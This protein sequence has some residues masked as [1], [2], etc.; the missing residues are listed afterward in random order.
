MLLLF[1]GG[2]SACKLKRIFLS[3]AENTHIITPFLV[4][5]THS[6]STM[7]KNK[8]NDNK[9][10]KGV[11]P[12]SFSVNNNN[13]GE[14]G[15]AREK[16]NTHHNQSINFPHIFFDHIFFC[17]RFCFHSVVCH[18]SCKTFP[19]FN[20]DNGAVFSV[21]NFINLH[22]LRHGRFF[23]VSLLAGCRWLLV[24]THCSFF[25]PVL[26]LSIHTHISFLFSFSFDF[27]PSPF[28]SCD[29]IAR[30]DQ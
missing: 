4:Q 8:N 3:I 16:Q 30:N 21:R 2:R 14:R 12:I 5:R 10:F 9:E 13:K 24:S 19:L 17:F 23:L 27:S 6:P 15:R 22:T 28:L 29:S 7:N 1:L 18:D 25:T 11:S 20:N 26:I